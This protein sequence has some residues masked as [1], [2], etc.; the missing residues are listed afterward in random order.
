MSTLTNPY[1][2]PGGYKAWVDNME[3]NYNALIAAQKQDPPAN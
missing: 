3:R 2:D 1:V